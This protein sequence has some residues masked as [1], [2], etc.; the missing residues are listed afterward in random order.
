MLVQAALATQADIH[1][2]AVARDTRWPAPAASMVAA[3]ASAVVVV[4]TAAVALAAAVAVDFTAAVA[5]TA[6][7]V[8]TGNSRK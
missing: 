5:V 8:D 1:S 2:Q 3:A 7:A 4:S 6:A